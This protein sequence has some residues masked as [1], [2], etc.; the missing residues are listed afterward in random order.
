MNIRQ[1]VK[2]SLII[3]NLKVIIF[4]IN[5]SLNKE[6]FYLNTQVN[7]E[8][9]LSKNMKM[10]LLAINKIDLEF[11]PGISEKKSLDIYKNVDEIINQEKFDILKGIG[12]KTDQKIKEYINL[13]EK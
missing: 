1:L 11:I 3:I 5:I 10:D 4:I 9:L 13:K 8:S 7:S 12:T 2:L 6:L